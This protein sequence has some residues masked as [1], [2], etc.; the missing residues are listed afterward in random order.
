M[1][2][3]QSVFTVDE[4]IIFFDPYFRRYA[5]EQNYLEIQSLN[6]GHFWLLIKDPTAEIPYT[7]LHKHRRNHS[8]HRQCGAKSIHSAVRRIKKHDL[9]VLKYKG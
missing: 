5:W 6:S 7:V 9:Y 3:F 1:S 4:L 2:D 8:Y